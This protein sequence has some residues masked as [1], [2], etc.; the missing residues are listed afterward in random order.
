MYCQECGTQLPEEA[1]FCPDCGTSTGAASSTPHGS[2]AEQQ[3]TPGG[4]TAT[5]Q[6]TAASPTVPARHRHFPFG[7][8]VA[9]VILVAAFWMLFTNY[10]NRSIR[11]LKGII[12]TQYNVGDSLGKVIN[13]NMSQA[14][15]SS[16]KRGND[17]YDVT[18]TGVEN[19]YDSMI[20]ATFRVTY[21][22]D[23][24][25]SVLTRASVNGQVC[26]DSS[27]LAVVMLLLYG[28]LDEDT[29]AGLMLWD[30]I[31]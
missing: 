7:T 23:A 19:M 29:L 16:E 3:Y 21:M 27:E 30:S 1:M 13:E 2:T 24:V 22:D 18:V 20:E 17:S 25:H 28:Q 15:W 14:K 12:F 8:I 26:T 4:P 5:P 11:D 9:A 10:E 31:W 6:P